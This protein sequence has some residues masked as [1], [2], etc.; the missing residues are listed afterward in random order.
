MLHNIGEAENFSPNSRH[1]DNSQSQKKPNDRH[2]HATL[3]LS[4]DRKPHSCHCNFSQKN[5]QPKMTGSNQFLKR[6]F[7]LF[8]C[9]LFFTRFISPSRL[10]FLY[11]YN[12]DLPK[13]QELKFDH[14]SKE[15]GWQSQPRSFVLF[16]ILNYS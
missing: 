6:T 5:R 11:R 3:I 8:V 7:H 9:F 1:D 14:V 2:R 4:K 15:R 10:C 12:A 16:R 13:T